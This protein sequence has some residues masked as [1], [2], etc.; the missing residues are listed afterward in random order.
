MSLRLFVKACS[1][2]AAL[3]CPAIGAESPEDLVAKGD[4][5]DR[6]LQATEALEYYLPAERLQPTNVHV[7]VC[8]ARQY[9]YL[10]ADAATREEKLRL[11]R[12]AL[13]YSQ[14][15][16]ALAPGNAEAQLAI[17][18]SYGKILP[19]L[20]TKEQ[21]KASGYIK[22]SVDRTLELDPQNDLAWH[23]LGRWH[24]TLSDVS[25]VK[26]GVASLIYG[27]LPQTTAEDAVKCFEKALEINP[28][29]LI[30]Y[31]ELGRTYA[32][33]GK[34]DEARRLI[35]KGLAMPNLEKDDLETKR[36]GQETLAK[37]Q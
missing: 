11:G 35:E 26:R 5:F 19:F 8:I 33:I 27:K 34:T 36:R 14:R 25:A 4:T 15:A 17:A 37:L 13:E 16:A 12:I 6:K 10:L 28:R 18:I 9:R 23:I 3:L 1:A 22:D 2:I 20:G 24:R 29:R 32:Q 30:H 31:V 7:L 21:I